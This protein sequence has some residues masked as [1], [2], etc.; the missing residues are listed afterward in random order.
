MTLVA[1]LLAVVIG[2]AG[3]VPVWAVDS[4]PDLTKVDRTVRDGPAYMTKQPLYLLAVFG[5]KAHLY[6]LIGVDAFLDLPQWKDY[7]RLL[8]LVDFIVVSRPGS[9]SDKIPKVVPEELLRPSQPA[10]QPDSRRPVPPLRR[11][12]A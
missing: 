8:D 2:L 6:F 9:A 12:S 4:L 10:D 7:R 5:P 3:V 1:K 11:P